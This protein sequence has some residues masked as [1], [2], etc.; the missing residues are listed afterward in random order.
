MDPLSTLRDRTKLFLQR[1]HSDDA[2]RIDRAIARNGSAKL[3][4]ELPPVLFTGNPFTLTPGACVA[5]IGLNP[6]WRENDAKRKIEYDLLK[7]SVRDR[8]Y[9]SYLRCRTSYF[10]D[11][12]TYYYG[13]YFTWP[14]RFIGEHLLRETFA[15]PSNRYSRMI[16]RKWIFNTDILPWFSKDVAHIDWNKVCEADDV[17]IR[18]WH[19]LL[20]A[21]LVA[22]RP[23]W[24]QFN[25]ND[26][27]SLRVIEK[28]LGQSLG[29]PRKTT[30]K[31][32]Y[33][34]YIGQTTKFGPSLPV[35]VH[36]FASRALTTETAKQIAKDFRA[37]LGR[38]V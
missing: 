8:D 2:K 20:Q 5:F 29:E 32:A 16:Y 34:Y 14:G 22:L 26:I 21:F 30:G 6:A 24:L 1:N 23:R 12:N 17:A 31:R 9:D 3:S 25:G 38:G 28:F 7:A 35:L 11:D 19:Q 37:E 36:P 33:K 4:A 10:D 15:P 27:G 18:E 13:R